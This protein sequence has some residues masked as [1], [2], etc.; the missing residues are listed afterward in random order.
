MRFFF[1][2]SLKSGLYNN[3]ILQQKGCK[4]IK[5]A[6]TGPE[7]QLWSLGPYPCMTPGDQVVEGE[8]WEVDNDEVIDHITL[9][10]Q[11]AG[12]SV[13]EIK[14]GKDDEAFAWIWPTAKAERYG[15]RVDTWPTTD[16][17]RHHESHVRSQQAVLASAS[18]SRRQATV[19]TH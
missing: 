16:Q 10:E 11:G 2:G 1:Y 17:L 15:K 9:M 3:R 18:P 8:I 13:T 6:K 19:L 12:Y 7:F 4:L 5:T 14:F